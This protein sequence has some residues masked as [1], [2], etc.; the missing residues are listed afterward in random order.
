MLYRATNKEEGLILEKGGESKNS[1]SSRSKTNGQKKY[2]QTK[3]F[4]DLPKPRRKGKTSCRVGIRAEEL[5]RNLTIQDIADQEYQT[6][7]KKCCTV[8]Q[9][10]IAPLDLSHENNI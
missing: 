6:P 7:K 1:N 10:E 4:K 5:K 8:I 9:T 2:L 3:R